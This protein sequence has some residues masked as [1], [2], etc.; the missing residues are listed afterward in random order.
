M[1]SEEGKPFLNFLEQEIWEVSS[2]SEAVYWAKRRKGFWNRP[3][4]SE[5]DG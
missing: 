2:T 5:V 3:D 1:I 4:M